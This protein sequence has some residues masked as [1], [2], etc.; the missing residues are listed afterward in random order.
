MYPL[1]INALIALV[2]VCLLGGHHSAAQNAKERVLPL[3][4]ALRRP[5]QALSCWTGPRG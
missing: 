2:G 3:L 4:P 5:G 1:R